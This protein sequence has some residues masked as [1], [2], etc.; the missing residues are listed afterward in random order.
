MNIIVDSKQ[1]NLS[2]NSSTTNNG[3]LN[4]V[5]LFNLNNILQK[6]KDI[7][8]N[9][10][11]I[12]HAQIPVSYYLINNTNNMLFITM[13]STGSF[14][15]LDPVVI[16]FV[17]GNYNA[18]TFST[19]LISQ[20]S[21]YSG[22]TLQLNTI[23]GIYT[24]QH[25]IYEFR[26]EKQST[27]QKILGLVSNTIYTSSYKTIIMPY[28][29]NFLGVNRIQIKSNVLQCSNIDSYSKG[30]SNVLC[31]IPVNANQFGLI[32]YI[33]ITNFKSFFQNTNLDYIDITITDE[34]NNI[35]D[36]NSIDVYITIQIDTY[37]QSLPD[38]YN[39]LKLFE[40]E[41]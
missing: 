18:S 39:L 32:N 25:N 4:S 16:Q 38:D 40:S 7:L 23:T 15:V 30:R 34:N 17:N 27:C 21:N 5:M 24:L 8:Y 11:S 9:Q 31:T 19:M 14:S 35:I 29:A 10:I 36:F 33:N 26:I 2:S 37:R 6:Q 28:P 1:I 20:L 13:L 41:L 12:S 3:S 22:F